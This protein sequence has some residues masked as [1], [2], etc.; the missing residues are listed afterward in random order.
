M[1]WRIQTRLAGGRTENKDVHLFSAAQ[2]VIFNTIF[3]YNVN[4]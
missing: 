4:I 3:F 1:V 2:S